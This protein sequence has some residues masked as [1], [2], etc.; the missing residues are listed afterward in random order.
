LKNT[1]IHRLEASAQAARKLGK[2]KDEGMALETAA[3]DS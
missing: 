3:S 2:R 1:S